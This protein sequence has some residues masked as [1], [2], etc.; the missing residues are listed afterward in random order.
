MTGTIWENLKSAAR[1]LML[2]RCD[3]VAILRPYPGGRKGQIFMLAP[4][5]TEVGTGMEIAEAK[6]LGDPPCVLVRSSA[7]S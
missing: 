6:L 1:S 4:R 3:D 7:I 5:R 2:S